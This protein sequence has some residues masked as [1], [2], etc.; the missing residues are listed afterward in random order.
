MNT[1]LEPRIAQ[2][3]DWGAYAPS[4]VGFGALAETIFFGFRAVVAPRLTTISD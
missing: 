2:M 3:L 4:R 1:N